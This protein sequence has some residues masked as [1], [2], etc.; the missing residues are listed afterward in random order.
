ME[1]KDFFHL[2][3]RSSVASGERFDARIIMDGKDVPFRVRDIHGRLFC[4][5]GIKKRL[6]CVFVL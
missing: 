6:C 4:F 2:H 3:E 1:M 5:C